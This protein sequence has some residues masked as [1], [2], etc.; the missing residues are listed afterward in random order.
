MWRGGP[1]VSAHLGE[2]ERLLHNALAAA[3]TRVDLQRRILGDSTYDGFT[4]PSIEAMSTRAAVFTNSG[5][6]QF[7]HGLRN[8][9][10]HSALPDSAYEMRLGETLTVRLVL[11]RDALLDDSIWNVQARAWI[12]DQQAAIDVIAALNDYMAAIVEHDR[13]LT[14]E[15]VAGNRAVIDEYEALAAEHR[16][17]FPP[18]TFRPR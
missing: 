7:V 12:Q 1:E 2:T 15:L 6:I 5:L 18:P 10:L 11:D 3:K 13:W 4:K 8:Y 16:S 17:R 14:E 9:M